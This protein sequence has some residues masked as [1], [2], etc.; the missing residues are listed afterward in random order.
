VKIHNAE[1]LVSA[2]EIANLTLAHD[3]LSAQIELGRLGL[4]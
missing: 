1:L 2:H 3:P 4:I